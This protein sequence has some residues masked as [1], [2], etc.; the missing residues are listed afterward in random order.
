M[1]H[2]AADLLAGTAQTELSRPNFPVAHSTY[3]YIQSDSASIR[4]RRWAGKST[5][6]LSSINTAAKSI[7][8]WCVEH[9]THG[10]LSLDQARQAL[11]QANSHVARTTIYRWLR[12]LREAELL[13]PHQSGWMLFDYGVKNRTRQQHLAATQAIR[14]CWR[15]RKRRLRA[16]QNTQKQGAKMT[17]PAVAPRYNHPSETPPEVQNS[18]NVPWSKRLKSP[19]PPSEVLEDHSAHVPHWGGGGGLF[20]KAQTPQADESLKASQ[21]AAPP[22]RRVWA[23]VMTPDEVKGHFLGTLFAGHD[24]DATDTE[25]SPERPTPP[26]PPPPTR[27]PSAGLSPVPEEAISIPPAQQQATLQ[28]LTE[29]V[30]RAQAKAPAARRAQPTQRVAAAPIPM[31]A[32]DEQGQPFDY[33]HLPPLPQN[34]TERKI[35]RAQIQMLADQMRF[36]ESGEMTRR[37]HRGEAEARCRQ[38]EQHKQ[39]RARREQHHGHSREPITAAQLDEI[40]GQA[41]IRPQARQD[42]LDAGYTARQVRCAF[43]QAKADKTCKMPAAALPHRLRSGAGGPQ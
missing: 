36:A 31:V 38:D 33:S 9:E 15:L 11:A 13:L 18:G 25:T 23:G 41:W 8:Q 17:T 6:R 43:A 28:A 21:G 29:Q 40:L 39:D 4:A 37:L 42:I 7:G 14:D 16:R 26:P 35:Y 1:M 34:D 22:K 30:A 19:P 27:A 3:I 10:I 12:W 2:R 32:T 20:A 5:Q 24:S